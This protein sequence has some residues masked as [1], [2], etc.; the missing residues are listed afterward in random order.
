MEERAIKKQLRLNWERCLAAV[1]PPSHDMQ[2]GWQVAW[3]S[4]LLL[5][6][7][8]KVSVSYRRK[9]AIMYGGTRIIFLKASS[10]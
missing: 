6:A 1:A 2:V 9:E 10:Y 4:A 7:E 3:S 8:G 5:S